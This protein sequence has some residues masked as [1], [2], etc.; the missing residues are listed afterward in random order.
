MATYVVGDVQGCFDELSELLNA[1][2][3]DPSTDRIFFVGDLVNRGPY[4]LQVLRWVYDHRRCA[5]TVLGNHDL[6]LL[7][8]WLG[9]A[10]AKQGDTLDAV[11]AADDAPLLLNW[12]VEQPLLR[13]VDGYAIAHAGVPPGWTLSKG[14]RQAENAR[15]KYSGA[16]RKHWFANMFGNKPVVWNKKLS[17]LEKF[18]FTINAFTRMRFC[19]GGELD[20]KFK[21]EVENAPEGLVPWFESSSNKLSER[22]IFGHWSALGLKVMPRYIALDTGC[23][24]GGQLSAFCIE[25]EQ[26]I[27]VPA[28][29]AYQCIDGN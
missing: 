4:S 18:R 13:Q 21:G 27:C 3:F 28:R 12:L 1:V 11:L 16:E 14:V 29:R 23:I 9:F 2:K 15:L 8:C 10:T 6:F 24:W 19:V 20:F 26:I 7:A 17:E 25:T 5:F 22:I